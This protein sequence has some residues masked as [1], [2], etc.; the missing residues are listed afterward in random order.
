MKPF[1]SELSPGPFQPN[2]NQDRIGGAGS[3]E[4]GAL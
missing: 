1:D 4:G 2:T 3:G